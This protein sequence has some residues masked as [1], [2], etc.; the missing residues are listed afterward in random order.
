MTKRERED[1]SR[2]RAQLLAK[3]EREGCHL[4]KRKRERESRV[5]L[6]L[7]G[8]CLDFWLLGEGLSPYSHGLGPYLL[9]LPCVHMHACLHACD[10]LSSFV[11]NGVTSFAMPMGHGSRLMHTYSH[12]QGFFHMPNSLAFHSC[13]AC[14]LYFHDFLIG[15]G[16]QVSMPSC[17]PCLPLCPSVLCLVRA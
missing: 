3:L 17:S 1:G 2:E 4:L 8:P 10:C 15:Q 6:L 5:R 16:C 9:H 7:G 11:P 12:A 14:M 13:H